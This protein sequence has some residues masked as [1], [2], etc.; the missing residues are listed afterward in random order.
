MGLEAAT[1]VRPVCR[2]Q[3]AEIPV[4][5]TTLMDSRIW[6]V[7]KQQG[8]IVPVAALVTRNGESSLIGADGNDLPVTVVAVANGVALVDG[9]DAGVRVRVPS[10]AAAS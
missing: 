1:P 8:V 3:C 7:P 6:L 4:Q 9:V 10:D 2:N 5:G